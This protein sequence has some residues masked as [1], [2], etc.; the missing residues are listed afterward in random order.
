MLYEE[1]EAIQQEER[2]SPDIVA[3]CSLMARILMRCLQQHDTRLERFLPL[4]DQS[5]EQQTAGTHDP[6]T[7]SKR[8]SQT[9]STL[10]KE[11]PD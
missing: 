6:M 7:A 5:K 11:L 2:L 9:K 4:P 1:R 3:F 8:N 10:R